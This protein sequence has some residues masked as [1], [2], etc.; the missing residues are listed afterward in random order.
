MCSSV[1]TDSEV[2][3]PLFRNNIAL[4]S[5]MENNIYLIVVLFCLCSKYIFVL[6]LFLCLFLLHT[7]KAMRWTYTGKCNHQS[8]LCTVETDRGVAYYCC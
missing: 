2:S 8:C 6:F 3:S 7:L 1:I 5:T 4:L